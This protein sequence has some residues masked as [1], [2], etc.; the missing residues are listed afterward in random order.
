M[1]FIERI[2][3]ALGGLRNEEKLV[4]YE[5]LCDGK[6]DIIYPLSRSAQKVGTVGRAHSGSYKDLDPHGSQ[7]GAYARSVASAELQSFFPEAIVVAPTNIKSQRENFALVTAA[8]LIRL[9]VPSE[10]V[11]TQEVSYSTYTELVE[12]MKIVLSGN[13]RHV[14]IVANDYQIERAK[15]MLEHIGELRDPNGYWKDVQGII[16]DF[17]KL[18]D[19]KVSFVFSEDVLTLKS[20]RHARLVEK[21]RKMELYQKTMDRELEGARQIRAGEYWQGK[22]PATTIKQ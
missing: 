17:K 11:Q 2:A 9:G 5:K 8:E 16:Q 10:K 7:S 14:A 15:A 19:M 20:P 12:M 6:P 22:E 4:E 1:G 3:N 13:V 21:V 18:P